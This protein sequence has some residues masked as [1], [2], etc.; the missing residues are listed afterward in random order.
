LVRERRSLKRGAQKQAK[1]TGRILTKGDKKMCQF[2]HIHE[3]AEEPSAYVNFIELVRKAL[4]KTKKNIRA[5]QP[6]QATT[7]ARAGIPCAAD[8]N[9]HINQGDMVR[10]RSK[11]EIEGMLDYRGTYKGCPFIEAMYSHCDKTYKVLKT[12]SYFYDEVKGKICKC[13]DLVV[14]DGTICFGKQ[15]LYSETC[16]LRCLVFWHKE[17]LE[18]VETD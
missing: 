1:T 10:V 11:V 13:K 12:A 6:H 15:K 5:R 7:E 4:S 2:K 14:I 18:K 9:M 17:W 16:D 8:R 3:M